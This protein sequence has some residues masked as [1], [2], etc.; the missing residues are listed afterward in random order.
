MV[1]EPAIPLYEEVVDGFNKLL[2]GPTA[3]VA[4][5]RA[6]SNSLR[7]AR[8]AAFGRFRERGFPSI[9]DEDWRYTQIARFLKDKYDLSGTFDQDQSALADKAEIPSLDS[10]RI[11]LVNGTWQRNASRGV[12]PSGLLLL[13]TAEAKQDP[14]FAHY[15]EQRTG[16]HH[17]TAL[18]AALFTDGIF[19]RVDANAVPDRPLHIVHVY[20]ADRNLLVQPRHV[21]IVNRNAA[22]TVIESV[23]SGSPP[24]GPR[25]LVNSVAEI[26]VEQDAQLE[27]ILI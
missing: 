17:F 2:S 11:V 23:V 16:D 15:F 8:E 4:G 21:V 12:P 18:N 27:H 22:L 19:I 24:D 14:V 6:E 20:T 7:R 1:Q 26:M 13:T 25:I 10:Y 5:P 3:A 9:K